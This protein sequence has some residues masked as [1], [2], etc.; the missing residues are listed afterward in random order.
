MWPFFIKKHYKM[1]II[2]IPCEPRVTLDQIFKSAFRYDTV[3]ECYLLAT[4]ASGGGGGAFPVSKAVNIDIE[5]KLI[6]G[7]TDT[8]VQAVTIEIDGVGGTIDGVAFAD[9]FGRTFGADLSDTL[10]GIAYT[11]PTSGGSTGTPRV[12]L[13]YVRD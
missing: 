12:I 11:I 9:G 1:A 5:E 13:T 3:E 4:D 7:T 6:A 2:K 8:G 10:N